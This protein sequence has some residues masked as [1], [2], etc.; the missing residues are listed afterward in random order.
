MIKRT[1]HAH[2]NYT[3]LKPFVNQSVKLN[4]AIRCKASGYM[5]LVLESL[6]YND[7]YGNPVYSIAHYGKQYGDSMRDPEMT[8]SVNCST[9]TIIPL[10]FRNDYMGISQELIQERNGKLMYSCS[11]LRDFDEFLWSWLKN[12]KAQGF[13]P[14]RAESIL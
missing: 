5:D 2:T 3:M 6:Q 10:S 14:E 12:I 9:E 4:G 1:R 7:C 11:L 13:S 8:F